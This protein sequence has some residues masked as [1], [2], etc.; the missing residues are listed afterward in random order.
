MVSSLITSWKIKGEKSGAMTDFIFLGS[1]IPAGGGCSDEIKRLLL[2]GRKAM[3]NLDSILK[4]R[5][6]NLLTQV[7]I[8][9]AMVFP[10]VI[11]RCE[12]GW[13]PKNWC[14]QTV[15]LESTLESLLDCNEI[16]PLNP[17]EVNP[18]YSLEGLLLKLKLQHFGH[19]M[20]RADSL[21]NTL[22]VG[23]T[24]SKRR[25]GQQRMRWLDSITDSMDMN[26]SKVQVTVE[27]RGAWCVTV[28][29]VAKSQAQ[30]CNWTTTRSTEYTVYYETDTQPPIWWQCHQWIFIATPLYSQFCKIN[31]HLI[32]CFWVKLTRLTCNISFLLRHCF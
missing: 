5:D 24:E 23:K 2:L 12:E 22:M 8:F 32:F 3:T 30:L 19:L 4:T 1:K 10:V 6:I 27:D 14:F 16:K 31:L 18:E 21:E 9:K 20:Q 17:K 28:L 29:E 26:L 13:A 11:Y 7:C 15:V 25:R